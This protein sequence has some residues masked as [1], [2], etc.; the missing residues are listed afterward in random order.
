MRSSG[1]E[2]TELRARGILRESKTRALISFGLPV[3]LDGPKQN[4][5]VAL[6]QVLKACAPLKN[7]RSHVRFSSQFFS[8]VV[9]LSPSTSSSY[10][11]WPAE[12]LPAKDSVT[13]SWRK[14]DFCIGYCLAF[15][16]NYL[17][18]FYDDD[19][20]TFECGRAFQDWELSQEDKCTWKMPVFAV[21]WLKTYY[22]HG[23]N[24]RHAKNVENVKK[25]RQINDIANERRER[26]SRQ[27]MEFPP[28]L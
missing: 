26:E 3:W 17:A 28:T 27:F 1:T 9:C 21:I 6:D 7:E 24:P 10:F 14:V 16:V 4:Y 22:L 5:A 12:R 2:N 15:W 8:C 13:R 11:E 20:K 19:I 25:I 23:D 18:I